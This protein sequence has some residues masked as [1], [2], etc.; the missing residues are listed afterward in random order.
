[1]MQKNIYSFEK[2][3]NELEKILEDQNTDEELLK[4]QKLN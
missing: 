4:W 1:M 2:D 3:K